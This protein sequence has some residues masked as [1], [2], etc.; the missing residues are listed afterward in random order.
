MALRHW[1]QL[2]HVR[3]DLFPLLD[4][5]ERRER[6]TK[7]TVLRRCKAI[8]DCRVRDAVHKFLTTS[9]GETIREYVHVLHAARTG[10][11]KSSHRLIHEPSRREVKQTESMVVITM[12]ITH[13]ASEYLEAISHGRSMIFWRVSLV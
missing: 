10:G 8:S 11:R 4:A 5:Y 1:N 7:R 9:S 6:T 3:W 13:F 2:E 12:A